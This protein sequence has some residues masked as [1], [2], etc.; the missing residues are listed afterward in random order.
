VT[1]ANPPRRFPFT[2]AKL[3]R[4]AA[5]ATG[6]DTWQD[7]EVPGL[8]LRVTPNGAKTFCLLRKVKGR[9]VRLT[10]GRFPGLSVEAV[11]RLAIKRLA[12]LADG[13]DPQAEKRAARAETTLEQLHAEWQA[14][15][16]KPHLRSAEAC[17]KLFARYLKTLAKR[18]LSEISQ[19]D[20]RALHTRI[21]STQ[22]KPTTANRVL[23]LL[24]TLLTFA[25]G[26]GY[27]GANPIEGIKR[28]REVSRARFMDAGELR[29]FFTSLQ[30]EADRTTRDFFL[31]AL[32]TGAR[33]ANVLG[34][35]WAD[36]DLQRGL[37]RIPGEK[38]KNGEAM[39]V[40]LAPSVVTLLQERRDLATGSPWVLASD[41]SATGHFVEPSPAWERIL[42]RAELIRLAALISERQGQDAAASAEAQRDALDAVEANRQEAFAR[43]LPAGSDPMALV[44]TEY[45]AQAAKAGVDPNQARMRDLRI[46]DLRRTLGSWQ[47]ATGASLPIIGRS[48][49]HKQVQTTAIYA[50]L[51]LDP[52][53]AAVEKA[54][55]AMLAAV[56][57]GTE[58]TKPTGTVP[59]ASATTDQQ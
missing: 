48:L 7:S 4:L 57:E 40:I 34:M 35:R 45:R 33:R 3:E 1:T 32:F 21:G 2:M 46:H 11:R 37:W 28:F 23:A 25:K 24:S 6:R 5:P 43:R 29:D 55:T 47:A 22:D 8:Q 27:T 59:T 56:G 12:D 54:A 52:V 16:A 36:L 19:V 18:R 58:P 44:L 50:R 51:S 41:I 10:L 39:V 14:K 9:P 26:N 30:M 17:A 13:I 20:I 53:R 49:G 38:S 31:L 42:A 15:H